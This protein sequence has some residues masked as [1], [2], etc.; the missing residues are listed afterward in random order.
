MWQNRK[1]T[2]FY[3][4]CP[5]NRQNKEHTYTYFWPHKNKL[6]KKKYHVCYSMNKHWSQ[7][8][9]NHANRQEI[10]TLLYHLFSYSFLHPKAN[11]S[12]SNWNKYS[13]NKSEQKKIR[14]H[15]LVSLFGNLQKHVYDV[16]THYYIN[17]WYNA[18]QLI[19]HYRPQNAPDQESW[20]QSSNWPA[21][22]NQYKR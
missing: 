20:R 12:H 17:K 16:V 7:N 13:Y 21:S 5:Q 15:H 3:T 8:A 2:H 4:K 9:T 10:K 6:E 1:I 14:N 11:I 19:Q 22:Q 18:F